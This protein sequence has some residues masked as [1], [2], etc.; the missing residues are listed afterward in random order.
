MDREVIKR[1][2]HYYEVDQM[3]YL[4]YGYY[5]LLYEEGRTALLRKANIPVRYLE[6][7]GILLPAISLSID[8]KKPAYYDDLLSIETLVEK[9]ANVRVYFIHHIRNQSGDLIN[10][11]RTGFCFVEAT[12]RKP[13]KPPEEVLK[14]W[15]RSN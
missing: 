12:S 7:Q 6:E 8:Y 3:N 11:G 13:I 9:L 2:V 4:F 15:G 1:R 10:I 14:V 5:P